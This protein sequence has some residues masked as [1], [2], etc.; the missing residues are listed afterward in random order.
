VL[1]PQGTALFLFLMVAFCGLLYWLAIARQTV[2]RILAA[3]LAFIPAMLFGVATIN[4]YY[5]YYQTW[6]GLAADLGGQGNP[7]SALPT[8]NTA[9]GKSLS[10]VL[11]SSINVTLAAQ[12]GQT[13]RLTVRGRASHL[14]RHV[15]VY[16]PPQYFRE[17]Y[18]GY[19]FPVIELIPGFPGGPQ[20]WINVVGVTNAYTTLLNDGVVK[21]A[22]L[23]MPDANGSRQVS[24]QCLN[25]AH[26]PQDATFL[27]LDLPRYL[28][29]V[30]RLQAPGQAWGIA[31]YSEGGFC[32]ANLALIYRLRYGYSGVLSGYFAP[33]RDQLGNPPRL[34][35]PFGRN[36]ALRRQN[37]PF[38]RLA[39]LPVSARIP[40][41][42]LGVG[43]LDPS[44]VTQ[45]RRFQQLLLARQ[46]RAQLH[47]EPGGGHTMTTWRALMPALLEWMTPRLTEAARHPERTL[48]PAAARRRGRGPGRATPSAGGAPPRAPGASRPPGTTPRATGRRAEI[49][50]RRT[51]SPWPGADGDRARPSS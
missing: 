25:V 5:D 40:S 23:V 17:A 50:H 49:D 41:F 3:C 45:A 44:G 21:P 38:D 16:L 19:R 34:V 30:L 46:P 18:R 22:A 32:A 13:F 2:F 1:E 31:G 42:W 9:S 6:G 20:D 48:T 15:Y 24:L 8:V 37:T 51:W 4:K 39:T 10:A 27:A 28:S 29:D 36:T 11:G 14:N 47:M 26:G 35:S 7:G 33:F 43:D 12:Q